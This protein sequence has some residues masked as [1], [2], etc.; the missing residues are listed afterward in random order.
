[1]KKNHAYR[2]IS[3]NPSVTKLLKIMKLTSILLFV[4]VIS[5]RADGYSQDVKVN[6]SL[7]GVK[8]TKFFKVIEKETKYRFAFSNDIIPDGRIVTINVK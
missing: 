4:C 2:W 5:V 7:N 6:L 8:L 3:T 1:M